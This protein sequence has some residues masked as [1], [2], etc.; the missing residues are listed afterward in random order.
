M[1]HTFTRMDPSD[2]ELSPYFTAYQALAT[3]PTKHN[4]QPPPELPVELGHLHNVSVTQSWDDT[5]KQRLHTRTLERHIKDKA[6]LIAAGQLG[7][8]LGERT[9]WLIKRGQIVPAKSNKTAA[10]LPLTPKEPYAN[11]VAEIELSD[12]SSQLQNRALSPGGIVIAIS[13][14]NTVIDKRFWTY[15]SIKDPLFRL[16]YPQSSTPPRI[17]DGPSLVDAFEMRDMLTYIENNAPDALLP[18][19]QYASHVGSVTVANFVAKQ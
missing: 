9:R 11:A 8:E 7:L 15:A 10:T 17:L 19:Q 3:D 5:A 6:T 1:R 12:I 13:G 14:F 16:A 2:S 4:L 18:P